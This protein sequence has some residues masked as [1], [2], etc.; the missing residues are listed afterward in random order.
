MKEKYSTNSL[1][2]CLPLQQ[3]SMAGKFFITKL[4]MSAVKDNA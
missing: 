4:K 2:Y 3:N 1:K